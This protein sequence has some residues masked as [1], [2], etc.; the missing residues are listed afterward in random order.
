MAVLFKYI[1][2]DSQIKHPE[3]ED[4]I[5]TLLL[6]ET[7]C[8]SSPSLSMVGNYIEVEAIGNDLEHW[9]MAYAHITPCLPTK[10]GI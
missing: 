7:H 2:A 3:P 10:M 8:H 4:H 5:G 1:Q 9:P 6:Q